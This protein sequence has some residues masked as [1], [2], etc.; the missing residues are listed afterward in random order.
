MVYLFLADGF[1]DVE[2]VATIDL[3]RRAD[4]EVKSVSISDSKKITSAHGIEIT[5]DLFFDEITEAEM[6][7][8]PGGAGHVKLA[9]HEKLNGLLK[10]YNAE[11]KYIAAICASPSVLGNLGILNG[12]KAVCY[13]GFEEKLLGAEVLYEPVIKDGNIITSRGPS[14]A[15]LFALE[16]IKA[17]KGERVSEQISSDILL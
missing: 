16:I 2:A 7:I 6:L 11:N 10:K 9:A 13:P 14:T 4:I 15:F 5:A 12:K 3:L 1:E 8:L 17:L